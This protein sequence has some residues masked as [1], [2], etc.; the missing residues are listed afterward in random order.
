MT[1]D[2]FNAGVN[3][4][5]AAIVAAAE[6][7]QAKVAEFEG[8]GAKTLLQPH[9]SLVEEAAMQY[10]RAVRDFESAC[11]QTLPKSF[12]VQLRENIGDAIDNLKDAALQHFDDRFDGG[13]E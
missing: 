10:G 9:E 3:R 6:K 8:E 7:M 2:E 13:A 1:N 12:Y 4:D 11:L 5:I